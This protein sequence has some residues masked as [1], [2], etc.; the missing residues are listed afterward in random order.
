LWDLTEGLRLLTVLLHPFMPATAAEMAVR[1][2]LSAG[3]TASWEEAVWGRLPTGLQV[4]MGASL[5][6]RIED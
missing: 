3:T 6:P 2:G 4:V 1:I 5:F